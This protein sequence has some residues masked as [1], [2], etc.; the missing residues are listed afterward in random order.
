MAASIGSVSKEFEAQCMEN[1]LAILRGSRWLTMWARKSS[2]QSSEVMAVVAPP[3]DVDHLEPCERPS[4][5]RDYRMLLQV[6]KN[7]HVAPDQRDARQYPALEVEVVGDVDRTMYVG[8]AVW[9]FAQ[10]FSPRAS[11]YR[12]RARLFCQVTLKAAT[13]PVGMRCTSISLGKS[14]LG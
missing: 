8:R 4:Q 12:N 13:S 10:R 14:G 3:Q 5:L 9:T 6:R 11:C 2:R 1:Y 7:Y